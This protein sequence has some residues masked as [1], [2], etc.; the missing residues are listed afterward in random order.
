M[1]SDPD[2]LALDDL[3]PSYYR[4]P[5]SVD[6]DLSTESLGTEEATPDRF[7]IDDIA[8]GHH[9]QPCGSIDC[10]LSAGLPKSVIRVADAA[11][12]SMFGK[13][14]IRLL[15]SDAGMQLLSN[16]VALQLQPRRTYNRKKRLRS[17]PPRAE[18]SGLRRSK[19][20]KR[21]E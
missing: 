1:S 4:R 7:T 17:T 12:V 11:P 15:R 9:R 16:F 5:R 3:V 6:S 14:V 13:P 2:R 8:P 10:F 20:I 18:S 19:R 21:P